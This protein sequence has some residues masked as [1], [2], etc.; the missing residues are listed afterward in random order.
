MTE[1]GESMVLSVPGTG[2]LLAATAVVAL[3]SG[4]AVTP[5][6]FT[7][8]Q[9]SRQGDEDRADMFKGGE[10]LSRPLTMSDAIARALKYN[11]DRRSK[12][13][14]EA[15]ALGQTQLDRWDMLP[16]LLADAGYSG[17]SQPNASRSRDLLTQTTPITVDPTYSQDR[18]SITADLGVSWNILD[19][20]VSYF[21]AHQNA[22]RVLIATERKRK[23]VHNLVQEV[24]FAFW[25]AAAY[26]VLKDDVDRTVAEAQM[27]LD[28]AKTV[29]RENLK[30]PVDSLRYR[31]SLMETLRQLTAIQQELSTAPIELA[32]LINLPPGSDFQ[33]DVPA[34]MQPLTWDIPLERMEDLAFQGNPDLREQGYLSRIAVDDTRKAILKMLP[35]ITLSASHN[36]DQNSFL[37]DNNWNTAGAMLSWNLMNLVSG[38]DAIAFADTNEE[39]V[40]ARRL[41][42]CMAVLAQVHVSE[43]QF[44]N[45]TS[46]FEQS[47][48]LWQ[49]DE[50]LAELSDA[51]TANDAQG[52]LERVAGHASAIASQLRRFQA[53]AQVEQAYGKMQA[54]L[55]Q[56]LMPETV[57][58]YDVKTLSDVVAVRLKEWGKGEAAE[59]VGPDAAPAVA[60]APAAVPAEPA[61]SV[62]PANGDDAHSSRSVVGG[63]TH[64]LENIFVATPA[65][66]TPVAL[67]R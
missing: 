22:D 67:S 58:S 15:L 40:K 28:K 35:G 14:E 50:R 27:A 49:V 42:L 6:P 36:Y 19:F 56:D 44:R 25:R 66:A 18:D 20:G 62:P 23:A 48:D 51:K 61:A 33:L 43:R 12:M 47:D 24:R 2:K 16:K 1:R 30:A 8:Q 65:A 37:V 39:V 34:D 31:K 17:R 10:P 9:L 59:P 3:L 53:Y 64:W 5:E 21:T 29:E 52:V 63:L 32:A 45:A 54:T 11:L 60:A 7:P 55:G 57:A 26:Q 38:P 41:A 13:M 46:Q 4:C